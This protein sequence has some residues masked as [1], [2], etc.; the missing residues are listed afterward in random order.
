MYPMFGSW[1]SSPASVRVAEPVWIKK[2]NVGSG[3]QATA[4]ILDEHLK[5]QNYKDAL[6]LL[7]T[8]FVQGKKLNKYAL[9]WMKDAADKGY[10]PIQYELF[11]YYKQLL[12][13]PQIGL[14]TAECQDAYELIIKTTVMI[15]MATHW[16]KTFKSDV[17]KTAHCKI[18]N[19]YV[20][21]EL[22]SFLK[23][24]LERYE[25]DQ[26]SLHEKV[27]TWIDDNKDSLKGISPAVIM[28]AGCQR[29]DLNF[30]NVKAGWVS[31]SD[32]NSWIKQNEIF[33]NSA[34]STYTSYETLMTGYQ[35]YSE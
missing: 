12:G 14:N 4:S 23:A 19:E 7:R 13:N 35:F 15:H 22:D 11:K 8:Y 27:A 31:K 16:F 2:N 20:F 34:K 29:G 3:Q 21:K 10:F 28:A 17:E 32:K 6:S 24:L 5:S 9:R 30:D 26:K 33:L 25:C 18:I 1:F